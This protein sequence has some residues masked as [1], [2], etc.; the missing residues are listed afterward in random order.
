MRYRA[1]VPSADRQVPGERAIA[2]TE[3]ASPAFSFNRHDQL[4]EEAGRLVPGAR[5]LLPIGEV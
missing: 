1:I 3:A 5:L 2:S 4:N